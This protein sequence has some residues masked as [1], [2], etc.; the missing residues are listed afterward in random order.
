MK[1]FFD[2]DGVLIDGWHADPSRRNAWDAT[3]EQDL[4]VD[5]T[6][7]QQAFF[8]TPTG[9]APSLMHECL[10]GKRDLKA[11]LR[12][13][14]P[15]VG[16]A[17]P[18]DKFVAYWFENDSNINASVLNIAKRLSKSPNLQLYIATGQEPCRADH[19]W[20]TLGFKEHF[21]DIF[22]SAKIGHLKNTAGFFESINATLSIKGGD[23][24]LFFD[25]TQVVV[26][27]ALKA[28][29]DACLFR[30]VDDMILHPRLRPHLT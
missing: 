19:L 8:K 22:Y 2:V 29:W 25:D 12:T 21:A 28:G 20:H 26:D 18:V 16:Y 24:P 23:P 11:A 10:A 14:L 9:A 5:R 1:V 15:K 30:T 3:I 7:F 17:G 6:A 13:I 4:G 27:Q